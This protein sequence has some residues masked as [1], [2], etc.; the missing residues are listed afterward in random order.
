MNFKP[1]L[2]LIFPTRCLGCR[3]ST[4]GEIACGDCL[5]VVSLNRTLFCGKCR[6][7]LA[8]NRKICH[9]N[10][11]FALGAATS[12][13]N[14]FAKELIHYLKFKF[15]KS[16]ADALGELLAKYARGAGLALESSVVIPL[17]LSAKRLR[18]RGFNQS[19]LIAESFAKRAGLA[20]PAG[21]LF[22]IRDSKPQSESKSAEERK[23]NVRAAFAVKSPALV[24]GRN[25]LLVDDV[26]TSGATMFEAAKALK[27]AGAKRIVALVAAMA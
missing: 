18:E 14:E 16:A 9:K 4:G 1:L 27:S 11:P 3:K 6:L 25:I 5:S 12:Y 24:A 7:R 15:V 19:E 26:I 2:N 21:M 22:R 20:A 13:S 8:T 17:P 23:E 10:H